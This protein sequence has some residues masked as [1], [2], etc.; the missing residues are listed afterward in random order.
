[1]NEWIARASRGQLALV[2]GLCCGI[3]AGLGVAVVGGEGWAGALPAAIGTG[4]GGGLVGGTLLH[5]Q[6]GRRT[7]A[8]GQ[9]PVPARRAAERASL[10]GPV[11][12]HPETRAAASALARTA[13]AEHRRRRVLGVVSALFILAMLVNLA[14]QASPWWWIGVAATGGL[15]VHGWFVFPRQLR[16]R[17]ELLQP[18][19]S[20]PDEARTR[21]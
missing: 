16:R 15:L 18:S 7:E 17:V 13:L 8:L 20:G 10:R 5:R 11:P 19:S 21:D 1:M 6:A 2:M 12:E 9:L 4:L 14:V 3:G